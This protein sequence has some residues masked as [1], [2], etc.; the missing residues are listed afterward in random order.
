M[1]VRVIPNVTRLRTFFNHVS[2]AMMTE[3][4]CVD[5]QDFIFM[6]KYKSREIFGFADRQIYGI[7]D[8]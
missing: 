6:Q 7:K 3:A 1:I 8:L 4:I 5:S 2:M